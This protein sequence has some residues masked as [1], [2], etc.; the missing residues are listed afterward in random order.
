MVLICL[1]FLLPFPTSAQD[2]SCY[3]SA[4]AQNDVWVIVYD[5]DDGGNRNQVLWRGKIEAGQ[6]VEVTSSA[7][8]KRYD[9]TLEPNQP[10]CGAVSAGCMNLISILTNYLPCS[11]NYSTNKPQFRRPVIVRSTISSNLM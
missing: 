3:I 10:Y 6:E 5:E 2:N 4:S 1:S 9:Y 7:G 11:G 8:T